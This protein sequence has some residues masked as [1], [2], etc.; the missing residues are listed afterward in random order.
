VYQI[1]E[2]TWCAVSFYFLF[3]PLP[4][5]HTFHSSRVSLNAIDFMA[6]DNWF[7]SHYSLLHS[8]LSRNTL[9]SFY[10]QLLLS[11]SGFYDPHS[12]PDCTRIGH[13]SSRVVGTNKGQTGWQLVKW[14]DFRVRHECIYNCVV[15]VT[16]IP[17]C[18]VK[19]CL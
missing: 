5:S 16:M 10:G 1:R 17:C 7:R 6:S 8:P 9:Q 15:F 14:M 2:R 3:P 18:A 12:A 4:L 19:V 13:S 11:S